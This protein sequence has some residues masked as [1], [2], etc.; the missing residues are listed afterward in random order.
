M[1]KNN[2]ETVA[3]LIVLVIPLTETN[4]HC[5]LFYC[6]CLILALLL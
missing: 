3:R 4:I 6:D 1:S 5:E 2:F